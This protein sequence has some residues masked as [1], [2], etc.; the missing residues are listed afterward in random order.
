MNTFVKVMPCHVPVEPRLAIDASA[1]QFSRPPRIC[2]NRV[3]K[4]IVLLAGVNLSHAIRKKLRV[5]LLTR[6]NDIGQV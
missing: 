1:R 3:L 5:G 2:A 4:Y 6:E